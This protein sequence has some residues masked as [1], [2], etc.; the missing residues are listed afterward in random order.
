MSQE[1]EPEACSTPEAEPPLHQQIN[2]TDVPIL[3]CSSDNS[4]IPSTCVLECDSTVNDYCLVDEDIALNGTNE[5]NT[6]ITIVGVFIVT[7][8]V[9]VTR[10]VT[11][12]LAPGAA[13]YVGRCLV[14]EEGSEIVVMVDTEVTNT[15]VLTTYDASCSSLHLH[16]N[17]KIEY[18]SSFDVCRYGTPFLQMQS[19]EGDGDIARLELVFVPTTSECSSELKVLVTSIAVSIAAV[20]L[21]V[22]VVVFAVPKL[23]SKVVPSVCKRNASEV[24]EKYV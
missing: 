10:D 8:N 23:R 1:Q 21:A 3:H 2:N 4:N 5:G 12:Q 14:L 17:I 20:M 19:E 7:G 18:A 24:L 11:L 13:L 6:T 16:E 9:T 22:I 15:Y